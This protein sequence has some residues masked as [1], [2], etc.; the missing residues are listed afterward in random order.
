MSL[1]L[2]GPSNTVIHRFNAQITGALCASVGFFCLARGLEQLAVPG[3]VAE[4][5]F[6]SDYDARVSLPGPGV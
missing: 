6:E 4:M 5:L 3:P 1:S 2:A